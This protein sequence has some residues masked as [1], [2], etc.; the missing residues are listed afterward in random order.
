MNKPDDNYILIVDDIPENVRIL[1]RFLSNEGYKVKA[2]LNADDAAERIKESHPDLVLLDIMMPGK[3][4]IELCKELKDDPTTTHIPIIMVSALTDTDVK[5]NAFNMGAQDYITKPFMAQE[6]LARVK[7]Q[8]TLKK[9]QEKLNKYIVKLTE[10]N[11]LKSNF[12]NILSHDMRNPLSGIIGVSDLLEKSDDL[13]REEIRQLAS[14]IQKSSH[15]LHEIVNQLLKVSTI[16]NSELSNDL[17]KIDMRELLRDVLE[18]QHSSARVKGIEI[19]IHTEE[20]LPDQVYIDGNKLKHILGNLL[21]NAIK[22]SHANS[23]IQ[24]TAA[25]DIAENQFTLSVQDQGIGMYSDMINNINSY[26]TPT[27]R[28]GTASEPSSGIGLHYI[29]QFLQTMGGTIHVASDPDKGSTFTIH[30]PAETTSAESES[31][32]N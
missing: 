5:V 25:Y 24:V 22:F 12:L 21:S 19:E 30:L 20:E 27:R 14:I 13:N 9:T 1:A 18:L 15:N 7:Y 11:Q 31:L 17:K 3:S 16:T 6:V 2:A 29:Y 26:I 4:G 10:L 28:T 32:Q 23:T 8:I